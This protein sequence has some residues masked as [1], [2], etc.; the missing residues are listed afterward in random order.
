MERAVKINLRSQSQLGGWRYAPRPDAGQDTSVTAMVFVSLASAREAG[1]L[2][3][4]ETI[5]RVTNYLRDQA[6]DERR[7]GFGADRRRIIEVHG[8]LSPHRR[9]PSQ[10]G[11]HDEAEHRAEARVAP[12]WRGV[13]S[14]VAH[15]P[16]VDGVR[17]TGG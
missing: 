13:R 14:S 11:E 7:G 8:E 3:P 1:I 9:R 5:E 4:T 6:F 10:G 17:R 12:G 15:D 2:V 16:N